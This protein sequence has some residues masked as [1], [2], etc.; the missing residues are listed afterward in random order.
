MDIDT[1]FSG[2]DV[3]SPPTNVVE[4]LS[5]AVFCDVTIICAVVDPLTDDISPWVVASVCAVS[6]FPGVVTFAA[7]VDDVRSDVVILDDIISDV[8]TDVTVTSGISVEGKL[9]TK[10]V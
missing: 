2:N 1:F 8:I 7:A 4:P 10:D 6:V 3:I 5:V 9:V